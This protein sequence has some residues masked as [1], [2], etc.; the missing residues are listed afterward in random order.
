MNSL[1]VY[2]SLYG[3]TQ[4]IAQVVASSLKTK[5]CTV[6]QVNNKT[7]SEADLIVFGSPTQGGKR[8]KAMEEFIRSRDLKNKQIATFDTRIDSNTQKIGLKLVMRIIKYASEKMTSL[9]LK[10]GAF[11][12]AQPEGFIVT[13]TKGPLKEGELQRAE[14]WAKTFNN[15]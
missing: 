5:S 8:T 3:N 2:D 11:S 12:I 6:S 9:S 14:L 4:K 10:Q 13:G 1:V 15:L 7:F